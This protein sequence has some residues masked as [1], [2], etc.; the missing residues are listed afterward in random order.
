ME[1]LLIIAALI[2]GLFFVFK[3]LEMK[4]I[5]KELQPLKHTIRD[6]LYVFI[7]GVLCLF[8]FINMN[9][10]INDFMNVITNTKGG[11]MKATQIF[12]DEPGF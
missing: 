6:S 3:L 12:T 9:S 11:D 7:S 1:K 5:T 2:A 8:L 4:F 10:S